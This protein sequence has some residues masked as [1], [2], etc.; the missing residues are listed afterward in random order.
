MRLSIRLFI[1]IGSRGF[2]RFAMDKTKEV[3]TAMI[4][5]PQNVYDYF[6]SM[7]MD[8]RSEMEKLKEDERVAK[9]HGDLRENRAY[10][11]AKEQ[12]TVKQSQINQIEDTMRL[13]KIVPQGAQSYTYVEPGTLVTIQEVST[14]KVESVYIVIDALGAPGQVDFDWN[15][16]TPDKVSDTSPLGQALIRKPRG[17]IVKSGKTYR[18]VDIQ[19]IDYEKFFEVEVAYE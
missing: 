4:E 16:L 3:V 19:P 8:L 18:V 17:A 2:R 5:V 13:C 6:E 12:M 15:Q 9:A 10:E 1:V 11:L 7:L 14:G